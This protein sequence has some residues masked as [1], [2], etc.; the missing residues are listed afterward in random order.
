MRIKF[1]NCWKAWAGKC[2]DRL[3]QEEI[4]G[5]VSIAENTLPDRLLIV[6]VDVQDNIRVAVANIVRAIG[7]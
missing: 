5:R 2:I 4:A 6:C 3:S 7:I 1:V